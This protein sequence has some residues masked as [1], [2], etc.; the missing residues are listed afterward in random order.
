M[1]MLACLGGA[2]SRESALVPVGHPGRDDA[3]LQPGNLGP[4]RQHVAGDQQVGHLELVSPAVRLLGVYQ[5]EVAIRAARNS[6]R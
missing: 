6:L 3:V 2:G 1:T 5:A 4:Q